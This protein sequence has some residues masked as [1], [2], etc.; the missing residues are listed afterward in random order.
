MIA[1]LDLDINTGVMTDANKQWASFPAGSSNTGLFFGYANR[2]Y[3]GSSSS[4]ASVTKLGFSG[5]PVVGQTGTLTVT[6]YAGGNWAA[7]AG[8][9]PTGTNAAMI[10]PEVPQGGAVPSTIRLVVRAG[11]NATTMTTT[12]DNTGSG[13]PLTLDSRVSLQGYGSVL[14]E[15]SGVASRRTAVMQSVFSVNDVVFSAE[16][17][18]LL[19]AA[20]SASN[21]TFVML[22]REC[23][24]LPAGRVPCSCCLPACMHYACRAGICLLA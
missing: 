5:N 4:G 6:P 16:R 2:A 23:D 17:P 18:L 19:T 11:A 21:P 3:W 20:Y 14:N 7:V 22:V 1:E 8:V 9:L 10:V 24:R 15:A 12:L 13:G